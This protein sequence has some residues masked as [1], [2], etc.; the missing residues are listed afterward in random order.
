VVER[1]LIAI[2]LTCAVAAQEQPPP[3]DTR[4]GVR[5]QLVQVPISV[6]DS[7]GRVVDGLEASDFTIIDNGKPINRADID[8]IA[9]GTAPISIVIAVQSSGI[10]TAALAKIRKV[11]SMI[12][13][14]ITGDRGCAAV[15]AFA[16]QVRWLSE[17]TNDAAKITDAFAGLSPGAEKAGRM[18][19]AVYEGIQMLSRRPRSRRV[20]L[21]ISESR[22]RG[23]ES[24]LEPT[25]KEAQIAGVTVYALTYSAFKT[26]MTA[27]PSDTAPVYLPNEP[28]KPRADPSAPPG[29]ENIPIPPPSQRVDILGGL[30]ELSRLSQ[31][32]TTL[33][34][35]QGTGGATYSF[36]RQDALED[37]IEKL[38]VDLHSQYVLSFAP[39]PASTEGYHR[40]EVRLNRKGDYRIRA[41]PGYW[42]GVTEAQQTQP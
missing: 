12:Q 37:A 13:P 3:P 24:T 17:C 29:R 28:E 2:L 27:K 9:T 1:F 31:P 35:A 21:L 33:I 15:V 26:A 23:S 11:G 10:S 18:L 25:L 8:T 39:G 41:R 32:E 38:G 5:S 20:L 34:L 14:L 42:A 22:D 19:D 16:S 7:K 36:T 4:F 30:S 40:I 6:T